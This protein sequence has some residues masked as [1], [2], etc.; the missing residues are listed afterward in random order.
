MMDGPHCFGTVRKPTG[1]S[2]PGV[3]Q[4]AL[5]VSEETY[6]ESNDVPKELL[7]ASK[8]ARAAD[9][10]ESDQ[11]SLSSSKQMTAYYLVRFDDVWY[12]RLPKH[13]HKDYTEQVLLHV[14]NFDHGLTNTV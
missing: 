1:Q 4:Q 14:L 12:N 7:E 5:F 6:R 13:R 8:F 11:P 2:P 3:T 10:A 9:K